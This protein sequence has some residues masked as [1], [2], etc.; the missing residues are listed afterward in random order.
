MIIPF[1]HKLQ[2]HCESGVTSNLLRHY[3]LPVSE[4]LAFGI[5]SGL[6][7]AH[8]PFVK[9]N[10]V[11]GT[12]YRIYPGQI[13]SN[14]CKRLGITY[15]SEKFSSAQKGM[16]RLSE[17][18]ERGTPTGCQVSVFYLPFL[19]E[20]FRFHFNAHNLIVYGQEKNIFHI[21]DPVMEEVVQIEAED[22]QKARYAKGYPEPKGRMYYIEKAPPQADLETAIQKGIKQTVFFMK[23]PPIP[24][25]GV[26]AI[27]FLSKQIKKYPEKLESRKATLYLGNIIRM[28]EEIGTGGAGFRFLY[29]AFLQEAAQITNRPALNELSQEMTQIGDLWRNFAYSTARI[30]KARTS[31]LVSF[32]ELSQQLLQIYQ[33]EKH[34][35]EL[36]GKVYS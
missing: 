20:V 26:N 27:S 12:T 15:R 16:Q 13:F 32:E 9:V 10:G 36:L 17:N 25:F 28:Q 21:S 5:G 1:D 35:Y 31:D 2:A 33:R 6:F 34:F 4:P 3:G 30:C 18:I 14:V 7:F 24:W 29:A 23:S 8:L 19:P 11:P 22:L